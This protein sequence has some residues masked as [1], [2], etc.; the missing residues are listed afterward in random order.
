MTNEIPLLIMNKHL[1]L[2]TVII[3]ALVVNFGDTS[4]LP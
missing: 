1:I 4:P 2:L 3:L